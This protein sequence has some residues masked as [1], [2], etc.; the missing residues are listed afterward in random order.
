M[1][2]MTQLELSSSGLV[3]ALLKG[4][5]VL[6]AGVGVVALMRHFSAALR[7]AVL[8]GVLAAALTLP[9]M[10]IALPTWAPL[11]LRSYSFVER[12]VN[13]SAS[14]SQGEPK[15]IVATIGSLD[16]FLNKASEKKPMGLPEFKISIVIVGIWGLGVVYFLSR[17]VASFYLLRNLV[18]TTAQVSRSDCWDALDSCQRQLGMERKVGLRLSDAEVGPFTCGILKPVIVLPSSM[19][20][21]SPERLRAVL[22][23]ELAHIQ[24]EDVASNLIA[25]FCCSFYWF[26]PFAWLAVRRANLEREQA[27]DDLVLKAGFDACSYAKHLLDLACGATRMKVPYTPSLGM[28]QSVGLERRVSF[29]LGEGVNRRK[30]SRTTMMAFGCALALICVPLAIFGTEPTDEIT[31]EI[32]SEEGEVADPGLLE[33]LQPQEEPGLSDLSGRESIFESSIPQNK[34][35]GGNELR[36]GSHTKPPKWSGKFG[37]QVYLEKLPEGI[38][39]SKATRV[40]RLEWL[41]AAEASDLIGSIFNVRVKANESSN[42][43]VCSGSE[44]DLSRVAAVIQDIESSASKMERATLTKLLDVDGDG[45][46]VLGDLRPAKPKAGVVMRI[47][48]IGGIQATEEISIQATLVSNRVDSVVLLV[49]KSCSYAKV[50]AMIEKL[51]DAGISQIK[52]EVLE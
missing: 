43:I 39:D 40:F 37:R 51:E 44:E 8:M 5:L 11:P 19:N 52:V 14:S 46:G 50:A 12:T 28:A 32:P 29:L 15:S 26:V 27:C 45:D 33:S 3:V 18:R 34:L 6:A 36:G 10:S 1:I 23:H 35:L 42:S 49:S 17:L 41:A 48:E 16:A 25:R 38:S 4:A 20:T 30:V 24:R 9:V 31:G 47:S 22:L 2:G 21:W 13:S 7:H